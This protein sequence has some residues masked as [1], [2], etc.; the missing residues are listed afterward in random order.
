ML[1]RVRQRLQPYVDGL[2][3]SASKL[4]LSA[5]SWTV[6]GL[7]LAS[8]SG[9]VYSRQ[10]IAAEI[11]A[12]TLLLASGFTDVLDGAV[13]RVRKTVSPRGGFLDSTLDRLGEVFIFTGILMGGQVDGTVVVLAASFSILVSYVRARAEAAGL[14]MSGIGIGE[15]AERILVLAVLSILGQ[16]WLG[17]V[18]VMFLAGLTFFQ[19][20]FWAVNRLT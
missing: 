15:R 4:P 7:L 12:G 9:L 2:G 5:Y 13:A 16:V 10:F 18:V 14:K 17:V 1:N 19:R 20:V 3:K 8:L 11:L 6:I